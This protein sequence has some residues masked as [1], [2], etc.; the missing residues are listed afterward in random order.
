MVAALKSKHIPFKVKDV[1][2]VATFSIYNSEDNS[3][4]DPQ[5]NIRNVKRDGS[6]D[7]WLLTDNDLWKWSKKSTWNHRCHTI[8]FDTNTQC[9][10]VEF[11]VPVIQ[12][13]A[14]PQNVPTETQS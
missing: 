4:S 7:Y 6:V 3:N 10:T 5:Y 8:E 14:A 12:F 2:V 11:Y 1:P 13:E 9:G